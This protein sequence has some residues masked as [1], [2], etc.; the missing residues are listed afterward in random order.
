MSRV[1]VVG[2]GLYGLIAAKTVL[3]IC[4]AYDEAQETLGIYASEIPS[5][6]T[7]SSES[8]KPVPALLIVD[9][10]SGLG[11]TWASDRLYPNLLS[12]NSYG[13][14]EFSDLPLASVVPPDPKDQDNQFI[15]GWKINRY[16]H[17]WSE[18][19][20]LLKHMRFNWKVSKISRLPTKEW[21]IEILTSRSPQSIVL[22]CDKLILATG[23]TSQPFSP[24]I[25]HADERSEMVPRIHA[26]DVGN[27][28]RDNLGYHPIPSTEKESSE[29]SD[30]RSIKA[31][32]L[33]RVAIQGGARSSFDFV[34]L[35][36]SLHKSNPEL[37]LKVENQEPIEVHWVIREQG[38]G[39][40]WMA[41]PMSELPNGQYVASDK[42]ASTRLCGILTPCVYSLPKRITLV[43]SPSALRWRFQT[44]GSWTRRFL[45]G[46]PVGRF[47]VRQL[48]K[49]VD[50]QVNKSADY[51]SDSKM[52]LLRPTRGIIDC[53]SSGGIANH[54]DLWETI[55]ASNVHVHRSE[56]EYVSGSASSDVHLINGTRIPSV[57]LIV[58]ATGYRPIVPIKFDPPDLGETLGLCCDNVDGDTEAL[59][60][61]YHRD[62]WT[63]F[64]GHV[65]S[66]FR[67]VF[68]S[69][70]FSRAESSRD[71]TSYRLFRRMV[72]PALVA[73]GDR[74]FVALGVVLSG[75]IAVVAEVQ[76][77]WAAAFL[78][79]GLDGDGAGHGPIQSPLRLNSTAVERLYES[80]SEDVVWGS[81]TGSGLDVDA[82]N[83]NDTLLRDLGLNPYRLGGS[84]WHELTGVYEPSSY[85]A[86][87]RD[88]RSARSGQ[89]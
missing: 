55:R 86:I 2:S 71:S 15:A 5:C 65:S 16:L 83:Y 47:L 8:G 70:M 19:W 76:A 30:D 61:Q 6:F 36:A 42:Q 57:D 66:H 34:H 69:S 21:R 7:Q 40:A 85:G 72:S 73:E 25:P 46:N 68:C 59:K 18:K 44:E 80:V 53:A 48:W 64:D 54:S 1:V 78:T 50:C 13:L 49:S 9:A 37:Q 29:D 43:R 62:Q 74:S 17:V 4:G 75:T 26:K 23:L 77:L 3:Q 38:S 87:V 60:Q 63:A 41:P 89:K 12:Q 28:C 27:Y 67:R 20:D 35:F 81:L 56:I 22:L 82:I 33:R 52:E 31:Q 45:H 24:D 32:V 51:T 58:Q 14:Y 39:A 88:Y 11:G 84:R 10:A 79:G